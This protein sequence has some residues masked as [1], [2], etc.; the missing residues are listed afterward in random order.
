[1]QPPREDRWYR[2]GWPWFLFL[3]PAAVVVASFATLWIAVSNPE[4]TVRDDYY[5]H[6]LELNRRIERAAAARARGLHAELTLA[7]DGTL[8]LRVEPVEGLPPSLELALLH[9][10]DSTQDQSLVLAQ[11]APGRYAG[12]LPGIPAGKRY[13]QLA[14]AA[15]DAAWALQGTLDGTQARLLP[16]AD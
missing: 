12:R 2:H 11:S 1:M 3:L 5:R 8:E 10:T 13:L 7:A 14:H 9:P 6:G 4:S 16:D 15:D